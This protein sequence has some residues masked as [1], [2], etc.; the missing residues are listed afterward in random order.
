MSGLFRSGLVKILFCK[1][2]YFRLFA[3]HLK[4]KYYE[5]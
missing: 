5:L 4:D 2:K 3:L 1:L